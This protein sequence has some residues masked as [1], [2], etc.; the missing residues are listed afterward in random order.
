MAKELPRKPG[1]PSRIVREDIVVEQIIETPRAGMAIHELILEAHQDNLRDRRQAI[2]YPF[3]R[4][5]SVRLPGISTV[6]FS[7]EISTT[8]IG[9]LHDMELPPGEIELA[10]PS[11][12]GFSIRVR[13]RILWCQPC[14][15]GWFISGGQFVGVASAI[16]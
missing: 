11:R 5:V 4:R 12:R 3:F 10:I 13:T 2:R 15:E 1:Q 14:G 6:A 9:L 7:R 8:G 16:G